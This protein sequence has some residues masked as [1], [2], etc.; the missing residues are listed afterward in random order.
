VTLMAVSWL[1]GTDQ[2]VTLGIPFEFMNAK[3]DFRNR[4][5]SNLNTLASHSSLLKCK[6]FSFT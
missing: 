6:A 2:L 3:F 4:E 5:P 1:D